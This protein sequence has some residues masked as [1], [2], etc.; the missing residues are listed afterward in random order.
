MSCYTLSSEPYVIWYRSLITL[1]FGPC[2]VLMVDTMGQPILVCD[3]SAHSLC[4]PSL[5]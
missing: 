5:D 3:V 2:T 4:Q 1:Q